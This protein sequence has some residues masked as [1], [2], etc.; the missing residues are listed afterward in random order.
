MHL[1]EVAQPFRAVNGP[2]PQYSW[3]FPEEVPES[4]SERCV[5]WNS[6]REYGWDAPIPKNKV[7]VKRACEGARKKAPFLDK[8]PGRSASDCPWH[9]LADKIPRQNPKKG[10]SM[11]SPRPRLGRPLGVT[12]SR[13]G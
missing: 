2:H 10:A 9:P 1:P 6:P 7:R 3:D 5:S 12:P 13:G 8:G 11:H 4:L